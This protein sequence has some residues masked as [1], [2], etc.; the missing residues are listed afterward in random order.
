MFGMLVC[1]AVFW[2][3]NVDVSYR[4]HH[5]DFPVRPALAVFQ[6]VEIH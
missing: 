5:P 2:Y 1:L 3:V 4:N 6:L